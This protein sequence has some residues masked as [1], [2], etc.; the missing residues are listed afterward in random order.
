MKFS[1]KHVFQGIFTKFVLAF[2]VMGFMPIMGMSYV[3]FNKLPETIEQ[4]MISNYEQTLLVA[5]KSMEIKV[6]EYNELTQSIYTFNSNDYS[7][8]KQI[9]SNDEYKFS[10]IDQQRVFTNFLN[11]I[12]Y[13]DEYIVNVYMLN[14]EH[15][16][17]DF[18]SRNRSLY[19]QDDNK[20]KIYDNTIFDNPRH[21]KML[22]THPDENF[23]V[24]DKFLV[25][26]VRNY[27]DLD[28]LPQKESIIGTIFIDVDITFIDKII[29]Q[30][31]LKE[32]GDVFVID[33]EGSLIYNPAKLDTNPAKELYNNIR[34]KDED[35]QSGYVLIDNK[36]TFFRNIE[37]SD[38]IIFSNI[39]QS[40][41]IHVIHGLQRWNILFLFVI[42]CML[43][44]VAF[45][46]SRELAKPVKSMMTQMEKIESGDLNTKIKIKA[47]YEMKQL[48]NAFNNMTSRLS[49]YIREVY[50]ARIKQNEAELNT[51]KSQIRPH[52]LYNTLEVIRMNAILEDADSTQ[53]MIYSLS[54]QLKYLI[55]DTDDS[56]SLDTEL[57]MIE[58]Y[59][60]IIDTS[61]K[62]RIT[63]E[64]D[65]ASHIRKYRIQKLLIQPIVENS[66]V[67][68]LKPKE[69]KGKVKVSAEEKDNTLIIKVIDDGIG[70]LVED[71][72]SMNDALKVGDVD[73]NDSSSQS[74]GIKNVHDRIQLVYGRK[75]GVKVSSKTNMGTL[76]EIT[77]PIRK[78]KLDENE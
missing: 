2:I 61:F 50:F 60:K 5:S 13:S 25:T 26:F 62:H 32:K 47:S 24:S 4:Y 77:I 17:F 34:S 10:S 27:L 70:I 56:V 23:F 68:G 19:I 49:D 69:G 22:P 40:D 18:V 31:D 20:E 33:T 16:L 51:I 71:I 73:E 21:L 54:E 1:I 12:M 43:I 42:G 9:I 65:V 53:E 48:A 35:I 55:G 11:G 66:V 36:Y 28:I 3:F 37:G 78:E 74:I 15:K 38:W 76:V 8:L 29:G 57:D 6:R 64:I 59:F 63:L 67:H 46:F 44:I 30:L 14:R 45:V 39:T 58:N 41:V 75:Y 7:L 52:Y 72:K